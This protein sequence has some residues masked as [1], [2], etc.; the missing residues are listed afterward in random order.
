MRFDL[1]TLIA[2][3]TASAFHMAIFPRHPV[4][5]LSCAT[6]AMTLFVTVRWVRSGLLSG[7]KLIIA[8]SFAGF[9]WMIA[10]VIATMLAHAIYYA[11][12]TGWPSTEVDYIDMP[13]AIALIF[14]MYGGGAAIGGLLI[15]L[16]L[17]G[18]VASGVVLPAPT[19]TGNHVVQRSTASGV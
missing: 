8:S 17:A 15:G 10:F 7:V 16:I 1:A 3:S 4:A 13:T 9:G 11:F 12:V 19:A 18:L 2:L 6:L 5:A 14:V